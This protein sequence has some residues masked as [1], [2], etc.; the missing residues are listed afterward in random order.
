[1]KQQECSTRIS[2]ENSAGAK[3]I[4]GDQCEYVAAFDSTLEWNTRSH[5]SRFSG[6]WKSQED[7]WS[8]DGRGS[9]FSQGGAKPKIYGAERGMVLNLRGGRGTYCTCTWYGKRSSHLQVQTS[10]AEG[11]ALRLNTFQEQILQPVHVWAGGVCTCTALLLYLICLEEMVTSTRIFQCTNGRFVC[12]TECRK[13]IMIKKLTDIEDFFM[14]PWE[15]TCWPN[16]FFWPQSIDPMME[17]TPLGVSM[18]QTL[19]LEANLEG[20]PWH[21]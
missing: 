3:E 16:M 15:W 19:N 2:V 1:M 13:D 18:S 12:E 10:P 4:K 7:L 8:R 5:K 9:L 20:R 6:A 11:T 14:L 17:P 21:S